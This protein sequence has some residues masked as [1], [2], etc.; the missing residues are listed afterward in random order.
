MNRRMWVNENKQKSTKKFYLEMEQHELKAVWKFN[1]HPPWTAR[2]HWHAEVSSRTACDLE[3]PQFCSTSSAPSA[4]PSATT[5]RV[6]GVFSTDAH[7]SDGNR[8]KPQLCSQNSEAYL[9]FQNTCSGIVP[10]PG[11]A[12]STPVSL[13]LLQKCPQTGSDVT[14]GSEEPLRTSV[15]SVVGDD[16]RDSS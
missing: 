2:T 5:R 8:P 1:Q 10:T 14:K 7:Q 4:M 16:A 15:A 3:C 13:S 6:H 12:A 11:S 9:P